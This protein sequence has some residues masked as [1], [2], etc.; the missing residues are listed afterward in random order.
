[1]LGTPL[2][3]GLVPRDEHRAYSEASAAARELGFR[4]LEASA[5]FE[6]YAGSGRVDVGTAALVVRSR[7]LL[8]AAYRLAD[9]GEGIE[10]VHLIRAMNEAAITLR[11]LSLD[12]E[13]NFLRW[14]IASVKR[15][16]SH[17]TA[18]RELE[19]RRR[20]AENLPA[21]TEADEPLGVLDAEGRARWEAARDANRTEIAQILNLVDRLESPGQQNTRSPEER[22]ERLPSV[23]VMAELADLLAQYEIAYRFDSSIA[24]HPSSLA[25]EQ[26]LR[27]GTRTA[28]V[29]AAEPTRS[30][31]DPY[32]TAAA[33]LWITLK[34]AGELIPALAIGGIDGVIDD[35]HALNAF[36]AQR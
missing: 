24:T 36:G 1:M 28:A 31:P 21:P 3:S 6:E 9:A 33:F 27:P 18:L 22:A 23:R 19:I 35:L 10:A 7:R 30:L 8:R 2:I 16:L 32:A 17:D 29:V 12:P 34:T 13:L 4:L 5:G 14:T 15:T 26:L 25:A 20:R 11:W